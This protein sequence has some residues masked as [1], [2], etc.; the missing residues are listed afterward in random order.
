MRHRYSLELR[1]T[2]EFDARLRRAART[3]ESAGLIEPGATTAERFHPHMT[4]LRASEIREV[5]AEAVAKRL[6]G[7]HAEIRFAAA[8]AFGE[9]RVLY[10]VPEV[11]SVLDR[12]RANAIDAA[13]LDE[14]DP[15]VYERKWTPHV[16][17]AYSVPEA[18]R[19]LAHTALAELL[20]LEG[21]WGS[22]EIWDLD[23]RPTELEY[24]I[25]LGAARRR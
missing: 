17:L 19:E 21:A 9:G 18:T 16:T 5:R 4:L 2:D 11:R 20:P 15:L 24:S 6:A 14:L 10:L 12:A 23:V 7:G 25:D 22:V 8:S 1:P 3:L 13:P